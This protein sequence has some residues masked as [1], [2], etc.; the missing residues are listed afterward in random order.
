MKKVTLMSLALLTVFLSAAV[1]PLAP[2]AAA[3]DPDAPYN[4]TATFNIIHGTIDVDWKCDSALFQTATVMRKESSSSSWEELDTVHETYYEDDATQLYPGK[5]YDYQV[6]NDAGSSATVNVIR[7]SFTVSAPL[8]VQGQGLDTTSIQV[9]WDNPNTFPVYTH[10]SYTRHGLND[11]MEVLVDPGIISTTLTGLT[12]DTDYDITLLF[13]TAYET[14]A[15]SPVIT[16]STLGAEADIPSPPSALT[17]QATG[18][19]EIVLNW[20]DNSNNEVGFELFRQ[21]GT[22]G[23]MELLT[24]LNADVTTYP[25][26]PL[27]PETTYYYQIRA[28][29]PAGESAFSNVA[30]ATTPAE[31]QAESMIMKFYAGSTQYLINGQTA[32]LDTA[33]VAIE[34]RIMLPIR[35]VVE[36]LGGTPAWD[37][38]TKKATINCNGHV[39]ILWLNQNTAMVDGVSKPIDDSNTAV[40]PLNANNRI[41]MP[42]RFVGENLDCGVLWNGGVNEAVITYPDPNA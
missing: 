11:N 26:A 30:S 18:S 12:E 14:S 21:T 23:T 29:N 20:T 25:D 8:N 42:L 36:P 19:D 32:L 4:L 9:N 16:V 2:S 10:V 31:V 24:T 17:A 28:L 39:L 38:N 33:P 34:N 15:A 40:M 27:T 35:Y 5:S 41:L 3:P 13:Y 6:K 1:F 7:G 22:T 37:P